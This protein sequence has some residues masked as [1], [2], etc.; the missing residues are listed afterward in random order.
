V[1]VC[2]HVS[3]DRGGPQMHVYTCV[4]AL[5]STHWTALKRTPLNLLVVGP[6]YLSVQNTPVL[7]RCSTIETDTIEARSVNV[8]ACM[9]GCAGGAHTLTHTL[10]HTH[11]HTHARTHARTHTHTHTHALS[12]WF[13]PPSISTRSLLTHPRRTTSR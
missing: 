7:K 11:T 1:S 6:Q 3:G 9:L 4:L 12:L 5:P 10:T 8:R 2:V 13:F